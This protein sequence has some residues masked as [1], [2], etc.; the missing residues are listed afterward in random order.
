MKQR[1]PRPKLSELK[2]TLT[3]GDQ[4]FYLS[5]RSVLVHARLAVSTEWLSKTPIAHAK[6]YMAY[7]S[8]RVFLC[9]SQPPIEAEDDLGLWPQALLDSSYEWDGDPQP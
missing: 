7:G 5:G 9:E 4:T 2:G 1:P 3:I 8:V 6:I